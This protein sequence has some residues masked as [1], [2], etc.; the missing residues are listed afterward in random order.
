MPRTTA[1]TS[2]CPECGCANQACYRELDS[3]TTICVVTGLVID[4]ET[5]EDEAAISFEGW[6]NDWAWDAQDC[7]WD[8]TDCAAC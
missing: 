1:R 4:D 3:R 5:P 6:P 2:D 7:A 8:E